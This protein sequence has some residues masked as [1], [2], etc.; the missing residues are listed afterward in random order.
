LF[1]PFDRMSNDPFGAIPAPQQ[2][3]ARSALTAAF[4]SAPIGAITSIYGGATSALIFRVESG[5]RPY[6]LRMEGEPSPLRNPH[7]YVSMRAAAEAGFAPRLLYVAETARVAVMEF[8]EQRPLRDYPGGPSALARALG[9]LLRRLQATAPFPAF[10][11]YPDIVARL[12]AHVRRTGLFANGLLD[13][14]VEHLVRVSE[15]YARDLPILVSS[16]ND[17][18]PRN[19][20]FDGERLWL[21]DWESAYRNDPLVDVAIMLDNLAPSPELEDLLLRSWPGRASD[22]ALRTRL[23]LVRALTRLYYAGVL[24]S[25]SATIPRDTP[26]ADLSAP[27]LSQFLQGMR[28]GRLGSGTPEMLHIMGK[29][30]LASFL[31]GDAVPALGDV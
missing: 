18:N 30:Y 19:I 29:M 7:Q 8:I 14:H 11:E 4:G 3:K 22:E 15:A 31:S 20:L 9:E 16:H 25:A 12:F 10:V 5:G 17:P 23:A 2:E 6:L 28:E 26:D 13:T 24:L 1:I 21:I 27:A